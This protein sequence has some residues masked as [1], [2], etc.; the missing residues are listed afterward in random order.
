MNC[1]SDCNQIQF[2]AFLIVKN[3]HISIPCAIAIILAIGG[4]MAGLFASHTSFAISIPISIVLL[5]SYIGVGLAIFFLWK[6]H[7]HNQADL[8]APFLREAALESSLIHQENALLLAEEE[9]VKL[10]QAKQHSSWLEANKEAITNFISSS[11]FQFFG[12][13]SKYNLPLDTME[14]QLEERAGRIQPPPPS[15]MKS[16][17]MVL[18]FTLPN[19]QIIPCFAVKLKRILLDKE[20]KIQ[21]HDHFFTAVMYPMFCFPGQF[22]KLE[23]KWTVAQGWYPSE[24]TSD[25]YPSFLFLRDSSGLDALLQGTHTFFELAGRPLT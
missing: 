10:G 1:I 3:K 12:D 23:W 16:S 11:S 8:S 25:H 17:V 13:A 22:P 24:K 6:Q 4:I 19:R 21:N 18:N 20:G 15:K 5:G 14:Y 9:E 7:K 2:A